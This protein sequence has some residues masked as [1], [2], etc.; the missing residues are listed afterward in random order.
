MAAR[1]LCRSRFLE[2]PLLHVRSIRRV[3]FDGA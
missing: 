3:R 2:Q 1:A